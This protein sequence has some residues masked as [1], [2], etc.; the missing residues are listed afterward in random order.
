MISPKHR[1]SPK[2]GMSPQRG[3][4]VLAAAASLV[5]VAACGGSGSSGSS[6][7]ARPSATAI[8]TATKDAALT[9]PPALASKSEIVVAADASYAPN[10]FYAEDNKT[11]IGLDVDLA[12]AIGQVLGKP[13]KIVNA[14]FDS[15]LPGLQAGKYDLAMSSFTDTKDR[16]KANDFVTYFT[17]GTSLMVKKGNPEG[18]NPDALC[19]KK[20]AAEKGT[21]QSDEDVPARSKAC[22]DGGKPAIDLLIFPDQG[23]ANLALQS[24]RADGV[25]AD[26][27][28]I[29]YQIKQTN[30]QFESVGQPY[31]TAPYGIAVQ[32]GKG[33]AEPVLAALKSVQSQGVYT[34]ILEAWGE[35]AGAL[36]TPGINGATS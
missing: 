24:G 6:A 3:V 26:S 35:T 5:T 18:L 30:G 14:P 21:T 11:I 29:A 33:V 36:N 7:A 1:T 19:G 2:R 20:V 22:T 16:E 15:I 8:P 31:A 4:A 28:V 32:K 23:G 27:P 17:A 25:L 34:K 10:E 12:N 13:V 9:L